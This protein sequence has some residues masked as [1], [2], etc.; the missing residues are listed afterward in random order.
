MC[1]LRALP[2]VFFASAAAWNV[3]TPVRADFADMLRRVPGEANVLVLIDAEQILASPL[4]QREGWRAKREADY[5]ARPLTFPPQATKLIRAGEFN[6][7]T[8]E[9]KW[10]IAILEAARIPALD[11]MAKKVQG[12]LDT[13]ANSS[14]V[15]SPRGW[16]AFKIGNSALG[17][18]FPANRQYL[19]R[20]MKAPPG[21]V[22]PYLLKAAESRNAKS[23]VVMAVDLEDVV[24]PQQLAERLKDL[25]S[26]KD[27]K[28]VAEI[29]AALATIQ[30]VRLEVAIPDKAYG[31]LTIDF[32]SNPSA[33]GKVAK[34]LFLEALGDAGVYIDDLEDWSVAADGKSVSLNGELSKSGLMRLSS[35]LELPSPPLDDS[36]RDADPVDSG[37]PKLYATQNYFKSIQTLANDLLSKKNESKSLGHY[38]MFIDTY[39]RRIDQL[40]LV[41]VDPDMQNYGLFIVQ[42]LR[43]ASTAFK[44]AGVRTG[45]RS[46][47]VYGGN[48]DY[49]GNQVGGN[50]SAVTGERR[51]IGAEEKAA[52]A[53]SGLSL[54]E[55]VA[56]ETSKIRRLMTERYKVNF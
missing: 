32:G 24:K 52:G 26:L 33:L 54:R 15:W 51:A 5:Q 17:V 22:S 21:R 8:H 43:Q 23:L 14:A 48:Y 11:Q 56:G 46:A 19:S 29:A 28:N 50:S 55:Q 1:R 30:G 27:A 37:D 25:D 41:N 31:K 34:P 44:G 36:G 18:M 16:Y 12:H 35:L 9:S 39:A 3:T 2:I 13:V 7:D 4:A 40:P 53:M 49:Y 45:A 6:M 47:G 38:A 42:S 20:W 10:Q